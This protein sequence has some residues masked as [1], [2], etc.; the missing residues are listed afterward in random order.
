VYI[1]V[2][3]RYSK[4]Y[5]GILR[6][7]G[8]ATEDCLGECNG[9]AVTDECGTCDVDTLNDCVPDCAGVWG[10]ASVLIL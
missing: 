6:C 5:L 1:G 2:S 9:L 10:G 8:D 7:G 3:F 4:H